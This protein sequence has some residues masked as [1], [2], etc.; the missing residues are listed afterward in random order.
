MVTIGIWGTSPEGKMKSQKKNAKNGKGFGNKHQGKNS[1]C[2]GGAAPGVLLSHYSETA[3]TEQRW[4]AAR[5]ADRKRN[6]H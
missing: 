2:K 5:W 3:Y 6:G 4:A 1:D